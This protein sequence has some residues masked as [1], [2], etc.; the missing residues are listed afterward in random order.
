MPT[1]IDDNGDVIAST[2]YTD[3]NGRHYINGVEVPEAVF[4]EYNTVGDDCERYRDALER[5]AG[6]DWFAD[7]DGRQKMARSVLASGDFRLPHEGVR[8]RER[9]ERMTAEADHWK[10]E[11][12]QM[13]NAH[14]ETSALAESFIAL[15][16]EAQDLLRRTCREHDDT[17]LRA[18]RLA[19]RERVS[20]ELG[21][22]SDS[23]PTGDPRCIDPGCVCRTAATRNE[24]SDDQHHE[25][26]DGPRPQDRPAVLR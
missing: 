3:T 5:I 8:L 24:D 12:A 14:S 26:E 15:L 11:Y 1:W 20:E 4:T 16:C 25:G 19:W 13:V 2:T 9:I 21:A 17:G 23:L 7:G 22:R 18:W 10:R 6:D